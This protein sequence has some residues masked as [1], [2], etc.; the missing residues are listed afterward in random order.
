MQ[1]A[2]T[3]ILEQ[4]LQTFPA[5]V[6]TQIGELGTRVSG[7]QRQR[8]ALARSLAAASAV[9]GMLVLDDPF[10][11]VDL[12]TEA[13][14]IASLRQ[15]FGSEMP[16]NQRATI[17]L[18]SHRLAAF[19]QADLIIVLD[20]GSILEKGTRLSS[21]GTNSLTASLSVILSIPLFIR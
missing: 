20:H 9:P 19:P 8:I 4:D 14:L 7:G 11:A 18:S 1:A 13:Q 10:S 17:L 21:S 2:H 16:K 12:D 3:A 15:T 6:D 5:G